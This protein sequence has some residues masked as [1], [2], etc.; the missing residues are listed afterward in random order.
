MAVLKFDETPYEV[1]REGLQ[2]KIINTGKLMSVLI[3]FT[4][5]PWGEAEPP[6]SHPHEQTCYIA[7]GEV[8]FKQEGEPDQYLK[9][10]DLFAVPSGKL[11][12]IQLLSKTAR[13][14]DNFTPLRE[15]FLK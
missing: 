3:D 8:I 7:E 14:I 4:D 1:L 15:E 9:A 10:G 12:T 13:L 2:R 11:H 5:G 6:H